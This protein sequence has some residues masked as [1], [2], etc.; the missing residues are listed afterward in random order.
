[1]LLLPY[2]A[3]MRFYLLCSLV[4]LLPAFCLAG[5]S[6]T[7]NDQGPV[8]FSQHKVIRIQPSSAE[9]LEQLRKLELEYE[10]SKPNLII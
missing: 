7:R 8:D 9:H 1:M 4:A 6:F 2:T 5:I 10:V 3:K